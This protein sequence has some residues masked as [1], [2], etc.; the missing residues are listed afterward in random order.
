MTTPGSFLRDVA[1]KIKNSDSS[2][3]GSTMQDFVKEAEI[4]V[5]LDH[6]CVVQFIGISTGPPVLV[7]LELVPLG[8]MLDFI[9]NNPESVRPEM[10]IPLWAAQI[11][12]GMRYLESK[13]F[14]HRDLAARNILLASKLQAK[15]SDFGL[16]RVLSGEKN[17]Y[18]ASKGGRWPVRWYAPGVVTD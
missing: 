10:E 6:H 5:K 9:I 2:V 14:I 15:I 4:M 12:C 3:E 16:S 1:V 13:R 18:A 8:S 7:V 17:Y 11:A